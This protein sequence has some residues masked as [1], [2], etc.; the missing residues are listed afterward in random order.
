MEMLVWLVALPV[1]LLLQCWI[2][3]GKFPEGLIFDPE[4]TYYWHRT[5]DP[6]TMQLVDND[7]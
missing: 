1:L 3:E 4:N 5:F 7:D 6:A 2:F